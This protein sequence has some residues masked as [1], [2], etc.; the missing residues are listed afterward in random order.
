MLAQDGNPLS[1]FYQRRTSLGVQKGSNANDLNAAATCDI[2]STDVGKY[3]HAQRHNMFDSDSTTAQLC[4][5]L[6]TTTISGF[7]ATGE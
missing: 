1:S 2:G 6:A 4:P 5:T 3:F 7:S